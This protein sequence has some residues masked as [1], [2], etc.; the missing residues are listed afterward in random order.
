MYA[1]ICAKWLE[2]ERRYTYVTYVKW[3]A[4]QRN[5]TSGKYCW[6]KMS[7]RRLLSFVK[8]WPKLEQMLRITENNGE[9]MARRVAIRHLD[10][11]NKEFLKL[12]GT[13]H[14]CFYTANHSL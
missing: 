7:R 13:L 6:I 9:E 1:I 4:D 2:D 12:C 5:A 11:D 10:R 8:P 14:L 3:N